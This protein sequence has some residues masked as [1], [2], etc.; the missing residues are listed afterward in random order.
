VW[1]FNYLRGRF[2]VLENEMLTAGLEVVT[3]LKPH[4]QRREQFEHSFATKKVFA[5]GMLPLPGKFHTTVSVPCCWPCGA[6][7]SI[8]H[9]P[10]LCR[11]CSAEGTLS[12]CD[13]LLIGDKSP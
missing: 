13:L 1:S 2:E 10:W 3:Y 7:L 11:G 5:A 8:W 6:A 4:P 12:F 9:M